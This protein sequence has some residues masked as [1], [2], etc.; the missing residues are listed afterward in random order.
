MTVSSYSTTASSNTAI[1]GVNISEGMSPSDV[2]NAIREQLKDVRSVWND[3]EWFILGDGDGTTTFTRASTTS[4]TV[5]SD[6]SST[7]HVGRRIKLVGSNT[8][9]I[10]GKIATSSYSSPNTTITFTFDSGSIDSGDSTVTVYLGSTY[11][12]PS[13]PVV[14][15]DDMSSNSAILPPS[16]QS[17]KAYVDSGTSTLTNKTIDS[18]NNTL[19]VDLSEAT[20][21]GTLSEFNTAVSDATLVSTT[22]AETLTNKTITSPVVSGLSLSDSNIVFEGA[23]DDAYETTLT[24]TDPTADRTVT[25]PNATTTLVGQD[26]TDTLTNKTISGSSNTLSNIG[27]S[28]LVNSSVNYG[29]V[30]LSLGGSDTT[31]AF[32]LTDATNYPTSSLTGTITNAQLDGSIAGTKLLDDAITTAKIIDDAVTTAKIVDNAVT[33]DKIA[34]SVIVTNAEHSAHT[35]DDSSFFT[36][37]A[38][39][40]RYFRQDST[41]TI[42]SGD[43][44]SASDS[45]IATTSAIDNRVIDLVDDV[46]GFVPI[47]NETSFPSA[48]PDVNNGT[49]T[50]VSVSS[51]G[52][53]RTPTA[54]T[55]TIANGSGSNTVTITGCG[56]TVLAAGYGVLVETTSTLH[57]YTFHRLVPKA[58]EVTTVASISGDITTVAN[59]TTD[60]GVV[61][62]LSTDIQV[63]AD[64]ED[65]TSATNAISNVGNNISDV[66]TVATDLSGSDNI[67][68]VATSISNVNSV[69]GSISNVNLVGGSISNVNTVASNISDVNSFAETYFISA[70]APSSPTVGDLWF[71]TT[72][73][74]MKVYTSGGWANAGS[75]VNG[76]SERFKYTATSGQTT[77]TGADDDGA[78]LAY[79]AGY[80]DVFLNGIKLVNGTD[81][82]ASSGTSIV[83]TSGATVNDILDIVTYG[84]FELAN[85]SIND[86]NDV[87]TAGV[88]N[89]QVLAYNST[90]SEFQP[91]T[92]DLTNLSA[93]N[94]TSGTVPD[95]RLSG[96]YTN[97]TG[98]TVNGNLSVDGGTIKLDGNY[99]TGADNI[100]LGDGALSSGSLSG[101]SNTA[102]GDDALRDNTTGVT[103]TGIGATTLRGNTTGIQNTGL[104]RGA[105]Q[106][107]STGNSNTAVGYNSLL[108]N[109]TSNNTAVGFQALKANTS[110][111]NQV[112]FGYGALQS[113]T[114]GNLNNA[115]GLQALEY[116][117]TGSDNVALGNSAMKLNTTGSSNIAIGNNA[118]A[119]NTDSGN[120]AVGYQAL[121]ANTSGSFN[122]SLGYQSLQSNTTGITNTG[123]GHS[124]L[125]DNT[126]ASKNTGL[127]YGGLFVNTTGASNTSVGAYSMYSNLTGSN[128]VAVGT[129]SLYN[130][131]AS[132]NTAVGYEALKANTTGEENVGLG[133]NAGLTNT[134][135]SEN[136]AIGHNASRNNLTGIRNTSVGT[137]ALYNNTASNNTAVGYN[138]GYLITTGSKNTIIGRYDGNQGGL[139]I[140]T[141]SNNIVLSDGDGNV[142]MYMISNG[143]IFFSNTTE[144]AI[145][146]GSV[147]GKMIDNADGA[148]LR[149]SRASTSTREHLVFYNPN[150]GVGSITTNGSSTSYNTSSDYRLKENVV[151]ITSATDRL[152]QLSPK[153]FNFIADA[154]TTVDGFLAHEVSSI[155]P[156]AITGTKDEIDADGNPV[157]QGIDQSKLVPLLVA[158]IKELEA[159]ITALEGV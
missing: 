6:I 21:T 3:K 118:L 108:S 149:S 123:I 23:T 56:S 119:N 73:S 137:S 143:D 4:I 79:D 107:N 145:G 43:T 24:V 82:T 20:V 31:P 63:L 152:K 49:G 140:R 113:N 65:G 88:T 67:G 87:S 121:T 134:T 33:I 75:S 139:D 40:A 39:D 11:S 27:N 77:F 124:A 122:S 41:E 36:T 84:T 81:F 127:G 99:P 142:R 8:G 154:D 146:G 94:L 157:Y 10:Y 74:V 66:T 138:S 14:D 136:T 105:L 158:T 54:G 50:I 13:I 106:T 133:R 34:D 111:S 130:N 153:R 55:V 42:S 100:A 64:I 132:N 60:I 141:S 26:T 45:Y 61:S 35:P 129:D 117:T 126:T 71:D 5:S 91:T 135:G 156:E 72:N 22:G 46:G 109:T 53:T 89:G 70:T 78:T 29:G 1:N 16:Q 155:V 147:D 116:N 19:T 115:F 93:S 120:T 69:G 37:S 83:L 150:G 125:M 9:T 44:W 97:I 48:N 2:N 112:A 151:D 7:H 28:S 86:A 76:T 110:G 57:T 114:T 38:S 17:V 59:D 131:T 12:N 90:A 103:N 101:G 58:T 102:I 128:N 68:T 30:S 159:R 80:V 62:G 15:Q 98:L 52:T 32:D 51:I 25:I 47:A 95:A 144:A 92:V 85:F 148:R 18:A 96:S 104:G